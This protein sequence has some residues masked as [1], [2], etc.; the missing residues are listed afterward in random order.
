MED[1]NIQRIFNF[2]E[3]DLQA[4]RDGHFTDKQRKRLVAED[5]GVKGCN[6]AGGIMLIL[7]GLIGVGI[8]LVSYPVMKSGGLGFTISFGLIWPLV[9]GGLG[10]FFLKSSL[11]KTVVKLQRVEGPVNI[12]KSVRSSY[13]STTHTSSSY[14]VYELH[15]GGRS[16]DVPKSLPDAMMQGDVYAIYYADFGPTG[17][18]KKE[19]ISAELLS[20]AGASPT[21]APSPATAN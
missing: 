10:F 14:T 9:W 1:E 8:A 11:Q 16:F 15:V 13:S 17:D 7:I 6:T 18:V 21:A 3:A 12:V 2:D 19:V 4:N 20:R 5:K